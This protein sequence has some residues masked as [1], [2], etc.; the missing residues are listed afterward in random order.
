MSGLDANSATD[1]GFKLPSQR[2][3]S[4]NERAWIGFLRILSCDSDPNLTLR[5]V[6]LLR[7]MIE[8]G[9]Q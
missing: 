5:R 8:E 7:L 2:A 6:Q 3:I 9:D 4:Q 1:A